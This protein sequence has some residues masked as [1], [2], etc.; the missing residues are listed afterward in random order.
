MQ[1]R[2]RED[3]LR[4]ASNHSGRGET[5]LPGDR[6]AHPDTSG[7]RTIGGGRA[8]WR[9]LSRR[10][11]SWPQYPIRTT[12]E[13]VGVPVA[14][15]AF[16]TEKGLG[17]RALCHSITPLGDVAFASV[18]VVSFPSAMAV[19]SLG[20]LTWALAGSAARSV[21]GSGRACRAAASL[22]TTRQ[23]QPAVVGVGRTNQ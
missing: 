14:R 2:S 10:R 4:S 12:P 9:E 5:R 17:V 16:P 7:R 19:V 13:S 1:P 18:R 6:G 23:N 3:C 11:D 8:T 15:R 20:P 22:E 21:R